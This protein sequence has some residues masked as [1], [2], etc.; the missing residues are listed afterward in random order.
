MSI[1]ASANLFSFL[2]M[3][4]VVITT[5]KVLVTTIAKTTRISTQ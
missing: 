1:S 4:K 3:W 5:A 2:L